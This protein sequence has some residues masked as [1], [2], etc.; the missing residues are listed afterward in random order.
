MHTV[1]RNKKSNC[2]IESIEG[3][4]KRL[5]PLLVNSSR[6]SRR[7][8]T[9]KQRERGSHG[10]QSD[11]D[12][13]QYRKTK[14]R[15]DYEMGVF[16]PKMFS[17]VLVGTQ[18]SESSMSLI[19]LDDDNDNRKEE[20][21]PLLSPFFSASIIQWRWRSRDSL[22]EDV[23]LL[24]R[25]LVTLF[26][27]AS[28]FIPETIVSHWRRL[29]LFPFYVSL[30]SSSCCKP[31]SSFLSIR[32]VSYIQIKKATMLYRNRD[33]VEWSKKERWSWRQEDL[34]RYDIQGMTCK[35]GNDIGINW[36][37]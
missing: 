36:G 4:N 30:V 8:F 6:V 3:R 7:K 2:C 15:Q 31:S 28:S 23:L 10:K 18:L 20:A 14:E 11:A 21:Q 26:V 22:P 13:K 1:S 5:L 37:I 24:E 16:F 34:L 19:P 32:V 33:K 9:V 17:T 27:A 12:N 35:E 29:C 25:H